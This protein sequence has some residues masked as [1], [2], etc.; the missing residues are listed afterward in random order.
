MPHLNVQLCLLQSHQDITKK[1]SNSFHPRL[2]LE[3]IIDDTNP[4]YA[5]LSHTWGS[6][7]FLF[8][9]LQAGITQRQKDTPSRGLSKILETCQRAKNDGLKYAWVD[10]CCIDKS[11]SVE[12]SEAIN[13]MFKWY[14]DSAAC[15]ICLEDV[16]NRGRQSSVVDIAQ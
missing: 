4:L 2:Q 10:T 9:H 14:E 5:I 12:L 13:S 16:S 15:Y 1:R 7:E 6:D 3:T 8:E 11:S